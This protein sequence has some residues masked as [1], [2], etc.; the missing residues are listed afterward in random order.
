MVDEPLAETMNLAAGDFPP[1]VSEVETLA[2][3]TA[4]GLRVAV[5]RIAAAPFALACRKAVSVAF[6]SGREMLI[7]D[8][9]AVHARE[10]VTE[11]AGAGYCRQGEVFEMKRQTYQERLAGLW[12]PSS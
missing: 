9:L 11:L 12:V 4:L 3:A 2:I 5:P 10:D 6:T 1:E 8:G 7:G